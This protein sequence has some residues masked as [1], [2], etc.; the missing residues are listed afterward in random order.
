MPHKKPR[1][2]RTRPD[3]FDEVWNEIRNL[4]ESDSGLEAKTIMEWLEQKYPGKFSPGQLRTLQRRI[5]DWRVLEGPDR[6]EV[7]FPQT[8]LPGRQSQSDYTWCNELEITID[9]RPF[10]HLVFHFMLPY[11]RWEFVAIAESESFESLTHGYACAVDLL[12]SV[13]PE[14]RTDNLA[15]AVPIGERHAFQQRWLDFLAYYDVTPSTN[16]PRRSHE[17]GSVEKSHDLFKRALD[18]RLRLRGSRNFGSVDAYESYLREMVTSRNGHRR[19]RLNEELKH[20]MPLPTRFFEDPRELYVTVSAWSTVVV[21]RAI[22]SVPSRL[23]GIKLRALVFKD[24]V[25][26]YYG[27]REIQ[28]MP[29]IGPGCRNINYRH[30][31]SHLL[32]KPR[33]FTHYQ[34]REELFPSSLFRKAFDY[35]LSNYGSDAG[36]REY[37]RVLN[38]AAVE[39][40]GSVATALELLFE[41]SEEISEDA[42]RKLITRRFENPDVH[43]DKTSL[44]QYDRLL[45]FRARGEEATA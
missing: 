4:L 1:K 22:Y 31:I 16:N 36:E 11:S 9:G 23:I 20:L 25:E 26:L 18:Q 42:I 19:E 5:R 10:P 21:Q 33:A 7:I 15:A 3:P 12:G 39:S 40:E 29:R 17:N 35:L 8:I 34:F 14:H 24:R 44:S 41:S 6:K 30:V 13:A 37:L 45:T 2:Y 38:L 27:P 28:C 43:V 32:R